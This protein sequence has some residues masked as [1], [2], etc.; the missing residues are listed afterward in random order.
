MSK[1]FT[2]KQFHINTEQCGMP[3][4]TDGILLGAW[5]NILQ[6]DS[7]LDIGCGAGL[8]S[9]MCAQRNAYASI[10]GLD[11][12]QNAIKAAIENV[13]QTPW[14]ERI[15]IKHQSLRSF[16]EG[17]LNTQPS[18]N[19]EISSIICNP[20][21]FNSGEH[22]FNTQRALARHTSSLSHYNLLNDCHQVLKLGG[23]A[24]FILPAKEGLAMIDLLGEVNEK[25]ETFLS[26]SRLTMVH[27][28]QN[29]PVTRLLIELTKH[30]SNLLINVTKN[31]LIIHEGGNYSTD[32]VE[33][34]KAFYLKM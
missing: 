20:P 32:F 22:S 21:Y 7:I 2:C 17:H 10:I 5:A 8:L 13:N 29:K 15:T 18:I 9:I 11:I 34:T 14:N 19:S 33:L 3:V 31:S 12:E 30:K 16:V 23:T 6:S 28:K 1:G 4:S 26:L 27:T 25:F 24:S